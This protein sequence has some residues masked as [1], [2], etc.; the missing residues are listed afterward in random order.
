[1]ENFKEKYLGESRR[2]YRE[3][4]C[5]LNNYE[6][7]SPWKISSE[8]WIKDLNKAPSR[9]LVSTGLPKVLWDHCIE[10]MVLICSHTAHTAYEIQ[11]EVPEKIMTGQTAD[12][13][14]I[15][16]YDWYEWVTLR[17]KTTSYPDD[18][19]TL[20]IYLGLETDVGSAMCYKIL[21]A[22]GQIS[23]RTTQTSLGP[24]HWV[25]GVNS[26]A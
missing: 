23:F 26:A 13:G 10:L 14:N 21:K 3:S 24:L 22:D 18:K 4:D 7:Y 1:M 2:K 20:G 17:D 9:K 12:I 6:P 15:C 11:G 5:H 25:N 16:E 19:R 8:G